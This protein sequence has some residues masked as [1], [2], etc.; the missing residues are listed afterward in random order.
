LRAPADLVRVARRVDELLPALPPSWRRGVK[1]L[2]KQVVGIAASPLVLG[3]MLLLAALV[4]R[5]AGRRRAGF[6]TAVVGVAILYVG[7]TG[8][9]GFALLAPLER[10][11]PPLGDDRS[12]SEFA[13]IVVLGSSYTPHEAIPATGALDPDG[14]ARIVEGVRLHRR[15][16]NGLLVVSGGAPPPWVPPSHGYARLARELGVPANRIV[17]LDQPRDTR[18]EAEAVARLL[19]SRPF[20][21]V[22]SAYHMPRAMRLMQRAGLRPVAAPTAHRLH[23]N[24]LRLSALTPGSSSLQRVERA[25]HEYL[26]L[27]AISAGLDWDTSECR[28]MSIVRVG[29]ARIARG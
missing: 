7:S 4:L 27:V 19:G 28:L 10:Q 20:V 9:A 8:I 16:G 22:T 14:L 5:I 17:V 11:Y 15:M 24:G 2:I 25:L 1:L 21:L 29:S 3:F 12:V 18:G 13:A 23:G 6:G 26:G